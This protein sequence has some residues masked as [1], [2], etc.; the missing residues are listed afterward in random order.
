MHEQN[1]I[2]KIPRDFLTAFDHADRQCGFDKVL[3]Q[4]RYPPSGK[5]SIPGDPEDL[6]YKRQ[7]DCFPG[8]L[9]TPARINV[10]VNA[11]CHGGCA[12]WTTALDY[13]QHKKPW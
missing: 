4:I 3:E 2:L 9:D 13:L 10:S 6:N 12:T 11:L 5:I 8:D 1:R 7:D